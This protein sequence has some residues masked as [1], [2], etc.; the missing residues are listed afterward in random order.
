MSSSKTKGL[1]TSFLQNLKSDI[2]A[3][4]VVF[5]VALPLCLG[6]SVAS[7][8][9]PIAGVIAGIVGGLVV[10]FISDSRLSVSGPAAGLTAIV[11][12]AI[13]DINSFPAFLT[14]VVLAGLI[15]ILLGIIKAGLLGQWFPSPVIKGMLSAIG[16]IL[17]MKQI[18]H[19]LGWDADFEGDFSFF[20]SD[21]ENSF[22]EIYKAVLLESPGAIII[23]GVCLLLLIF[24]NKFV[25]SKINWLP[26]PLMAIVAGLAIN[27]LFGEYLPAYHLGG[28]EL[29]NLPEGNWQSNFTF[30]DFSSITNPL[31][32]K[33]ALVIALVASLESLL[34]IDAVDKLDPSHKTTNMNRE[35]LAQGF[36][37]FTSGLIGGI[38]VTAVIVRSAANVQAGGKSKI[39]AILHALL[40]LVFVFFL[41]DLLR[42]IPLSALAAIL[43]LIGYKLVQPAL[44]MDMYKKGK[45]QFIPFAVTI[46]AILFTDLLIGI[47]IGFAFSAT[48]ILLRSLKRLPFVVKESESSDDTRI[49]FSGDV[50]FLHKPSIFSALNAITEGS[51]VV[52][53][54]SKASYIDPDV[55]NTFSDFQYNAIDKNIKIT[56]IGM[57]KFPL[58]ISN[59][60]H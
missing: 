15:Q 47:I 45:D 4:I 41:P 28:K 26:G 21:R 36:G 5:L 22:T 56:L 27:L 20:Q 48:F 18:P 16:L 52:L 30:A 53:D 58:I 14:A 7:G 23:S 17:I 12:T 33:A 34:S 35:L 31:V 43:I 11:A 8:A 2:P 37:N 9:P 38:P 39:S 13:M 3:G 25:A 6:I 59:S 49:T 24:W 44:V 51:N 60:N 46:T 29:V 19:A 50:S 54:A 42:L 10:T 32:L 40:L 55:L 57:E 1:D